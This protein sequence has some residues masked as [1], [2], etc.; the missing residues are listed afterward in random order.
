[1][2]KED[3][4]FVEID[5]EK[6][7][8]KEAE[9]ESDD[10]DEESEPDEEVEEKIDQAAEKIVSEL[11]IDELKEKVNDIE[12]NNE[13]SDKAASILDFESRM[14]KE[15]E[16]MTSEEKI[17]GF[18]QGM[19]YDDEATMKA[20]SEGTDSDGG[21]LF[22]DEFRSEII[23]D[24]LEAPRMRGE[25]RVIPMRR[26][27]MNIPTLTSRPQVTWTDENQAKSTTT[28][29]F[30]EKT[31]TVEKMAA[32]LYVSDELVAD[33]TEVDIVEFIVELFSDAIG[34][35]EDR[36]I[37]RGDGSSQ[38]TGI[39]Q[40]KDDGNIQTVSTATSGSYAPED[41]IDLKYDLPAKYSNDAKFYA[42]RNTIRDMR[43]MKDSDGRFYWQEPVSEDGSPTFLGHEVMEVNDLPESEVYFGE[44]NRAYWLGDRQRMTVK[45]SQDTETAFTKDQTAVRVVS[46]IAGNVVLPE[47]VRA[48]ES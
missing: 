27:V 25:V 22:P 17:V 30:G 13:V 4:K 36:V 18:F 10:E 14:D 20:L 45:T 48:L 8:L 32:I 12:E 16:N 9:E 38:P 3:K 21:Y 23:Q 11:G 19:L 28:A 35:E 1:M 47:A 5:G 40:D 42:H 34:E 33:S 44:L 41:F 31:L 15:V 2:G 6:Y 37:W 46:R 43:K 39:V 29:D 7:E 24:I 26:N